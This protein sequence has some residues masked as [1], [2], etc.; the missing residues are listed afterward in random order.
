MVRHISAAFVLLVALGPGSNDS[1]PSLLKPRAE[2]CSNA[3][4]P[5]CFILQD[6]APPP[7]PAGAQERKE[8]VVNIF[9]YGSL[10]NP[11]SR[12]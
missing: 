5:S 7:G 4:A 10:I 6:D 9:G 2:I 1:S 3:A 8:D 12:A 11:D